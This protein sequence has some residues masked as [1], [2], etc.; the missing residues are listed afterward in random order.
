MRRFLLP[1]LT[2]AFTTSVVAAEDVPAPLANLLPDVPRGKVVEM[3]LWRSKIYPNTTRAW[4][5]YVPAQYRPESPAALMVFADGQEF[6]DRRGSWRVPVV[7][8]Q[9]IAE[10]AVPPVIAVMIAPGSAV[11]VGT[12][13]RP[14]AP[15]QRN[16]ELEGLGDRGAR[17]LLEEILPEIEKQYRVSSDPEMRALAGS[18][19]GGVC[20]FTAAWERPDVF[21]KVLCLNGTFTNICGANGYP[22]LIRK[23]ERKP[24]RVLLDSLDNDVETVAGHSRLSI[25]QMHAALKYMGYDCRFEGGGNQAAVPESASFPAALRWLWR[26]DHPAPRINTKGDL[27]GDLTL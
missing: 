5:I 2:L 9:L 27:A 21:H 12:S 3:P 6:L 19:S 17:F 16:V 23:T 8:D 26:Q 18:G 25:L 13:A 24:L 14:G 10:G 7:L 20:A 22:A 4:S 1:L 11:S 15:T